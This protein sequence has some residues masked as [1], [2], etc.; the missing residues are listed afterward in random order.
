MCAD[1]EGNSVEKSFQLCI[2]C[3]H[4]ICKFHITV[5]IVSEKKYEALVYFST[6]PHNKRKLFYLY[7]VVQI[8]PGRFVCKQVTVCP[9]HIWTTLC[10]WKILG[11]GVSHVIQKNLCCTSL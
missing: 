3:T 4:D 2:G 5:I 10:I 9:G 11:V 8:W 7:K 6:A 1:N